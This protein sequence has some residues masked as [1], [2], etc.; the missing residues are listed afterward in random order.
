VS[1]SIYFHD[2]PCIS[3][4][5]L[6]DSESI[7]ESWKSRWVLYGF[8]VGAVHNQ[9]PQEPPTSQMKEKG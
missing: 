6:K 7:E 4:V 1:I 8:V 5:Y 3:F 2:F 9:D